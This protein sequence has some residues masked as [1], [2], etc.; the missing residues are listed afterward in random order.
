MNSETNTA[1]DNEQVIRDERER[2]TS[3][4]SQLLETH[5]FWGYL[6]LQMRLI[7]DVSLPHLA[8]TDCYRTIWYNPLQTR[9]LNIRQLGFVLAHEIGHSVFATNERQGVRNPFLWNC[10]T[11]YAIN[12]I[13]AEICHPGGWQKRPLYEVPNTKLENGEEIKIL[14]DKQYDGMIAEMIYERLA[15]DELQKP[16]IIKL[17]LRMPKQPGQHDDE[18]AGSGGDNSDNDPGEELVELPN[19]LDH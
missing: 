9:Q 4:R 15:E 14:L 16:S 13:V 18:D 3:I 5:P 12:R 8:A 1:L 17:T 7:P 10:A 6:L 19:T 11:D 2:L